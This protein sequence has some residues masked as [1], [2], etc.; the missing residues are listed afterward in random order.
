MNENTHASDPTDKPL[1]PR[2]NKY[3]AETGYCSRREADRLITAGL[4]TIDELPAEL[5]SRVHEGQVVRVD[6]QPILPDEDDVY[7]ALYK[8]IDITCTTDQRRGDNII[9]FMKYPK[10]IFPIGRLDR[11]S[12]GLILLTNDGDIVNKILRAKY[13]HEKEY[14]VKV[15]RPLTDE[16]IEGMT[17]GVPILNTVTL[18]CRLIPEGPRTFRLILT[19]G[20]NRQIRRMC[21]HF[22]YQVERLV[23][24]RIMHITLGNMKPGE[25]RYLTHKEIHELHR[26]T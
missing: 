21:E 7:I 11:D 2:I 4:V 26:L 5:G 23:R 1:D 8:P 12:E 6:G 16:F 22:G 9:D 14:R 3:M 20:L 19:Q 15:D 24:V 18:P 25:W 10:R 17:N 13:H